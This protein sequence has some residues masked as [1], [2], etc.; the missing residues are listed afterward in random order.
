MTKLTQFNDAALTTEEQNNATGG[1]RRERLL[2]KYRPSGQDGDFYPLT[3]NELRGLG[4]RSQ[5][6]ILKQYNRR[7]RRSY[8]GRN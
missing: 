3:E 5:N 6:R 4:R 8:Y 1:R 2:N 7:I